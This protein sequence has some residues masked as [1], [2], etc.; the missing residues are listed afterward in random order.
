MLT[1]SDLYSSSLNLKGY[2][3]TSGY[4]PP[5]RL[6]KSLSVRVHQLGEKQNTL[7]EILVI[8]REKQDAHRVVTATEGME[9]G[10][11]AALMLKEG[12]SRLP[13]MCGEKTRGNPGQG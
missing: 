5:L 10:A 8:C 12:I 13:V 1:E 9:I 2:R 4:H 7:F 6:S 11:A 3:M